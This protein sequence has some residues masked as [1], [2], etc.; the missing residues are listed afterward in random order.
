MPDSLQKR[1]KYLMLSKS[2]AANTSIDEHSFKGNPCWKAYSQNGP[3][4]TTP[5]FLEAGAICF[6]F[7]PINGSHGAYSRILSC[8][9]NYAV[10]GHWSAESHAIQ[11]LKYPNGRLRNHHDILWYV[12]PSTYF[13][14]CTYGSTKGPPTVWKVTGLSEQASPSSVASRST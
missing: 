13:P 3:T 6:Y 5:F 4:Q 9:G 11:P 7:K 12:S 14:F 1:D 8:G 2:D 10:M